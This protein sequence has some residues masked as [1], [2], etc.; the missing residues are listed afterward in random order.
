MALAGGE[1]DDNM[2]GTRV[3]VLVTAAGGSAE[4]G[5]VEV[6][7]P[8]LDLAGD[9]DAAALPGH[10]VP[11]EQ[12]GPVAAAEE[13]AA[14]AAVDEPPHAVIPVPP[15]GGGLGGDAAG[16]ALG[17]DEAGEVRGVV[18][19]AEHGGCSMECAQAAEEARVAGQAAPGVADEGGAGEEGRVGREAEEDLRDAVVRCRLRRRRGGVAGGRLAHGRGLHFS[20]LNRGWMD[21]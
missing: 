4:H 16:D 8:L 3:A 12:L 18:E 6:E 19:E 10:G 7:G 15:E 13:G 20:N 21:T 14:V 11:D 5:G 2:E 9:G 1:H 17:G